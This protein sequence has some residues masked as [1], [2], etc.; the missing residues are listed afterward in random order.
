MKHI[1]SPD[2]ELYKHLKKLASSARARTKTG[3][4]LIDGD[5]LLR[6]WLARHG[7]PPMVVTDEDAADASS[8][9]A[10][11]KL[12]ARS[13]H[14]VMSRVLLR[15]IAPVETPSG[16]LAVVP[17][18]A[19]PPPPDI[20]FALLVE[21]IQSPGNLGGMLRSAAAAGVQAAFL[22][23]KCVDAWSPKSLRAG[24]G[25]QFVLPVV[26]GADLLRIA[27]DFRGTRIATVAH[28]GRNLFEADLSGPFALMIGNEG[29]GL[30]D[31]LGALATLRLSIPMTPGI[32][33]LN[34]AAATAVCLFE[35][36]RQRAAERDGKR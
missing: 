11:L 3:Y 23:A 8:I 2:N 33:S 30:S 12:C 7:A 25:A 14:V 16:V 29:S 10:L 36:A 20:R 4:T 22:S 28:D 15:Q 27:A 31:S 6:A 1:R 5:H 21:D 34:A 19:M 17:M 32:E 18:A 24:M 13:E 35:A 9:A 26:E